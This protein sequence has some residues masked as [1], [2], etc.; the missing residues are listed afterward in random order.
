M[1]L[2]G[3]NLFDVI[4]QQVIKK[5]DAFPY[6]YPLFYRIKWKGGHNFEVVAWQE[7]WGAEFNFVSFQ[8]KLSK[9]DIKRYINDILRYMTE[10]EK[11]KFLEEFGED[12]LG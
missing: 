7:K 5:Y 4:K 2:R 3:R 6:S 1:W 8:I 9:A 11:E 10:E 12:V